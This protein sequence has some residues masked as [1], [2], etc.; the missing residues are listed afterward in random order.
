MMH[1]KEDYYAGTNLF[2]PGYNVQLGISDEYIMDVL[3]CQ[4]RND[5][6]TLEPFLENYKSAYGDIPEK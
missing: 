6:G 2:K 4:D 3:V 1:M 5:Q